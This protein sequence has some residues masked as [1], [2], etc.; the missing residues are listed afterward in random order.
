[1]SI[2]K[3]GGRDF[4]N[5]AYQLA[6]Q[7]ETKETLKIHKTNQNIKQNRINQ[8]AEA[9][10]LEKEAIRSDMLVND[11]SL[12]DINESLSPIKST[13]EGA[14]EKPQFKLNAFNT[15]QPENRQFYEVPPSALANSALNKDVKVGIQQNNPI[16][17]LELQ[18]RHAALQNNTNQTILGIAT[19]LPYSS[20]LSDIPSTIPVLNNKKGKGLLKGFGL[21]LGLSA[22]LL[23]AL[24]H[25]DLIGKK[26]LNV[27]QHNLS[28]KQKVIDP[29]E[30]A[31][32]NSGSIKD[33]SAFTTDIKKMGELQDVALPAELQGKTKEQLT[34]AQNKQKTSAAAPAPN[35][36]TSTLNSE[37][38]TTIHVGSGYSDNELGHAALSV[39]CDDK[40]R[41]YDF[42]RYG[43]ITPMQ[44]GPIPLT[45]NLSPTGE[46]I[47]NVWNNVDSY[48]KH[49]S[50]Y[51]AGTNNRRITS[52]YSYGISRQQADNIFGYFDKL[53]SRGQ[54][55]RKPTGTTSSFKLQQD[56]HALTNNCVTISLDGFKQANPKVGVSGVQF[57]NVDKAIKD[58]K[59]MKI[60]LATQNKPTQLF[61]PGNLKDYLDSKVDIQYDKV[62]NK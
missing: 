40:T 33:P 6:K 28:T 5:E 22:G 2:I 48:L 31:A 25:T 3:A 59:L 18:A 7:I 8:R 37:C 57:I 1:M 35:K 4:W 41:L 60:G 9:K 10:A 12:E 16:A 15:T 56:Y 20:A 29:L 53:I 44:V 50:Y 42:G 24:N 21:A 45:G 58:A 46:G 49:E 52:N 43:K 51:G 36:K 32:I 26:A 47:L 38:T 11:L 13:Y 55:Y 14:K 62:T 23:G 39:T 30:K 61:L 54:P 17:A 27:A 34:L 19:T